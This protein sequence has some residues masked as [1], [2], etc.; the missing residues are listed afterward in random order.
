VEN[1]GQPLQKS[2]ENLGEKPIIFRGVR[3]LRPRE[4]ATLRSSVS[5]ENAAVD[6]DVCLYTGMRYVELQRLHDNPDWLDI[7]RRYVYLPRGSMMKRQAKQRERWVK[8]NGPGVKAVLEFV[9]KGRNLPSGQGFGQNLR[10]WA[11]D[12]GMQ[13]EGLCAKTFRKTW[14]SWLVLSYPSRLTEILASTG[15]T[16]TTALTYYLAMPFVESEKADMGPYVSDVF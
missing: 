13:P 7:G 3:V 12:A 16:Q 10:R 14:E 9:Q 11:T 2:A 6:L 8:L 15:H 1:F 4:F 5:Q